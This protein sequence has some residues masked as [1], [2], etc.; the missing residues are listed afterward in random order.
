MAQKIL[1]VKNLSIILGQQTIFKNLTFEALAGETTA[2][3]GPNGAGK[4][5]LFRS[6]IGSLRYQGEISWAPHVKI[7]YVPQ[8]FDLDR[9]LS[10]T[11]SDFLNL[12]SDLA[13]L[14]KTAVHEVM[15]L[16]HLKTEQLK[17]PLS[18]LSGGELQRALIAF[19]LLDAPNVLLFDEP[20]V[21]VDLP[22]GE[23]IYQT[24]HHL[25]DQKNITLIFISH[26]LNL[27]YRYADKVVCLNKAMFC[28]GSPKE[29][30]KPEILDQLY[31]SKMLHHLHQHEQ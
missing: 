20:T 16:V 19:A 5:V 7:G 31:G 2:I 1:D 24:L 3:I 29:T 8:R 15:K 6:L 9:N 23:Q 10:L 27:V 21:N 11:L 26:D 14:D 17:H 4:T 12:K 30:L 18:H 13:K 28:F 25:Q 22:G